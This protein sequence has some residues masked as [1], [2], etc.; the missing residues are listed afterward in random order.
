MQESGITP[1]I[2]EIRAFVA[3]N[4][5]IE[6][7]DDALEYAVIDLIGDGVTWAVGIGFLN[8]FYGEGQTSSLP[9]S[10]VSEQILFNA[11]NGQVASLWVTNRI[12]LNGGYTPKTNEEVTKMSNNLEAITTVS[13]TTLAF[14]G[15]CFADEVA[16]EDMQAIAEWAQENHRMFMSVVTDEDEAI[17]IG[18]E[19]KPLGQN[20]YCLTYHEDYETV[21]AVAGMGLDQR[22]DKTDGVKTLHLKTLVSV[23]PSN[24]TQPQAARMKNACINYYTNYGNPDNSV[25]VFANGHAGGGM[26]FDTVMGIDWLQNVVQVSVFNGL[27]SRRKT[28]QTNAGMTKITY[29][30]VLGLDEG[31]KAGLIAAGQWNSEGVGAIETGDFLSNGYYVYHEPI[32][33]QPQVIRETRAA[34]PYTVLIKGSGALHEVDILL[35]PE[36]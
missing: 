26:F 7:V 27:A 5:G 25:A 10:Q 23:T 19:L 9:T 30:I 15:F 33:S 2:E 3:D 31:V 35:T 28:A 22:Y 13:Q 8:I 34:P 1:T 17:S 4:I 6:A 21:G 12:I 24:I 18:E 14:Y 20:H 11:Q 29:D 32:T 36:V 16:T